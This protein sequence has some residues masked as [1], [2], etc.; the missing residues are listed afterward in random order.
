MDRYKYSCGMDRYCD[1]ATTLQSHC[2]AGGYFDCTTGVIA[3]TLNG[4]S[5]YSG[6]YKGTGCTVRALYVALSVLRGVPYRYGRGT[7]GVVQRYSRGPARTTAQKLQVLHG[8]SRYSTNCNGRAIVLEGYCGGTAW[9]Y[10]VDRSAIPS[11][12][13]VVSSV[14][15]P[16]VRRGRS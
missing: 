15:R 2:N 16:Q 4:S 5:R 8:D 6:Y 3:Q 11:A 13:A 9:T 7:D 12:F 14:V 1:I 10:V